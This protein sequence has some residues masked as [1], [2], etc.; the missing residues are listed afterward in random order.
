MGHAE[1]PLGHVV[2]KELAADDERREDRARVEA[3]EEGAQVASR[4][5]RALK[6]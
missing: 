6:P 1:E 5:E 2:E 3:H 4:G